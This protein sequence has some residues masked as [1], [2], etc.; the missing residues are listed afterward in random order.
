M[1]DCSMVEP[2]RSDQQAQEEAEKENQYSSIYTTGV[3]EHQLP[4]REDWM[5]AVYNKMMSLD[6][7]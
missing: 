5:V 1:I 6:A 4:F 7:A 2:V 3:S